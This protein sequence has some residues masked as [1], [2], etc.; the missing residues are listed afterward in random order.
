MAA[1]HDLDDVAFERAVENATKSLAALED[2][3]RKLDP[4]DSL[5]PELDEAR[6][7]LREARDFA[8]DRLEKRRAEAA[9]RA[10]DAL[11]QA[12]DTEHDLS[13]KAGELSRRGKEN[14]GPLP[15]ELAERLDKAGSVMREAARELAE[16]HGDRAV[17]LQREAQ[18]MLE[19]SETSRTA[20]QDADE[21][22]DG[23]KED[24][25]GPKGDTAL[26]GTVP[27]RDEAARAEAFRRRVLD[28]LGGA[29]RERLG[30][31]IR[32]YAEGLLE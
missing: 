1:A 16:G 6:K 32:R 10:R 26:G 19:Q 20:Q 24:D 27:E 13:E 7:A 2:V 22:R 5:Q 14:E 15:K 12:S 30:P 23:R 29:R 3:A 11:R 8:A 4:G 31:A 17:E 18:R 9:A 21:G 25:A 28:G